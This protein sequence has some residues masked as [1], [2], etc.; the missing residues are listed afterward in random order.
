M[1]H[2]E[3]QKLQK[4]ES[5]INSRYYSDITKLLEINGGSERRYSSS[6]SGSLL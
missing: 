3:L 4:F 6:L 1:A 2:F 5:N